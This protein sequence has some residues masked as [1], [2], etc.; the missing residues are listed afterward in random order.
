MDYLA[1][2]GCTTAE[3]MGPY[4]TGVAYMA[5]SSSAMSLVDLSR[6]R[7][8]RVQVRMVRPPARLRE[9]QDYHL[10]WLGISSG[11]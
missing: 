11:H 8:T 6:D 4:R 5:T 10:G 2:A 9:E 3:F 7:D 1:T